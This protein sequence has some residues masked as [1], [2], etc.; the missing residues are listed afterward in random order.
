MKIY[1]NRSVCG[2]DP[3]RRLTCVINIRLSEAAKVV[4]N[5]LTFD[6]ASR[7]LK[8]FV[9]VYQILFVIVEKLL[10]EPVK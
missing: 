6:D 8:R 9:N 1:G 4:G 3:R 10:I 7:T 5:V 2:V